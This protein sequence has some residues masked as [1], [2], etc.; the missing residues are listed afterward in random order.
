VHA[1][2]ATRWIAALLHWEVARQMDVL[3]DNGHCW[4]RELVIYSSDAP[5]AAAARLW[6]EESHRTSA[7]PIEP[8]SGRGHLTLISLVVAGI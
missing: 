4:L 2:T 7:R 8:A 3:R 5:E 1:T 6:R